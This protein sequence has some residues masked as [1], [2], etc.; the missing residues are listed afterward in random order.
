MVVI[1][2]CQYTKK[3]LYIQKGLQLV[4]LGFC[5]NNKNTKPESSRFDNLII[6]VEKTWSPKQ[7]MWLLQLQEVNS[8]S[9]YTSKSMKQPRRLPIVNAL[10]AGRW[11]HSSY[12]SMH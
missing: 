6:I 9:L 5:I 2:L 10:A 4:V 8:V 12:R 7:A 11:N 3:P 1:Q